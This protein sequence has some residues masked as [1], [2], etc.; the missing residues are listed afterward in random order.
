MPTLSVSIGFKY[1]VV[2]R[3]AMV[4]PKSQQEEK[5]LEKIILNMYIYEY[6]FYIKYY[7]I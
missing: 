1:P 5:R 7:Y 6:V 3:G 4:L 2:R